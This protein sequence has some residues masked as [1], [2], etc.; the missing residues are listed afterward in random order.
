[1]RP[2]K[3][4]G[5]FRGEFGRYLGQFKTYKDVNRDVIVDSIFARRRL[6]SVVDLRNRKLKSNY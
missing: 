6:Y 1:M 3:D 4:G 2:S 5:Y